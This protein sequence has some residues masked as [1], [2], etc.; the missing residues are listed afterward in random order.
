MVYSH[1]ISE[2]TVTNLTH[3]GGLAMLAVYL[4]HDLHLGL[5]AGNTALLLVMASVGL[6]GG[7]IALAPFIDRIAPQRLIPI[8]IMVSICGYLGMLVAARRLA[9]GAVP[10]AHRRGLRRQQQCRR[11][12]AS[13]CPPA[14]HA[15]HSPSMR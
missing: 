6:R 3:F 13:Y 10:A 2:L 11:R 7:R 5:S 4:A 9:G 1:L 15:A 12:T 8:T 14:T